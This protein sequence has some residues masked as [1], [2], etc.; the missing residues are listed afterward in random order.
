MAFFNGLLGIP[1]HTWY[2]DGLGPAR[3]FGGRLPSGCVVLLEELE[4]AIKYQGARGPGVFVD[5]S[6]LGAV[7]PTRLVIELLAALGL[8][9]SDLVSVADAAAQQSAAELT[10]QARKRNAA[11]SSPG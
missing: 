9:Q 7:G 4:L 3:G 2:E 6:M 10:S 8:S 5:A 11:Q 1:V